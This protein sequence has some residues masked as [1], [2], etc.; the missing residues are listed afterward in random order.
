MKST[1]EKA[2]AIVKK[3]NSK[4]KETKEKERAINPDGLY[5]FKPA[6]HIDPG[7]GK[8]FVSIPIPVPKVVKGVPILDTQTMVVY[9][10]GIFPLNEEEFTAKRIFPRNIPALSFPPRWEMSDIQEFTSNVGNVDNVASV[11]VEKKNN[12]DTYREMF[13]ILLYL[14]DFQNRGQYTLYALWA[15]MTYVYP[16]F[17]AIPFINL[18]G[19]PGSGKSKV[20][21][22]FQQVCFN[23]ESTNNTS[24]AALFH[25]VELNMSTILIDE[26]EKLTGLEK[27][28]E[29][30]LLLNACYKKGGAVMRWNP[31]TKKIDRHYAYAPAL[32]AAINSLDPT[33]YQRCIG[34]V[35]LKTVTNKGEIV[36]SDNTYNWQDIRNRLYRFIFTASEEIEKIYLT[37]TF[38]GL[39]ARNLEK[40]APILSI[41][42][43]L[44]SSQDNTKIFDEVMSLAKEDI[45]N[46]DILTET[47][48][49]TLRAVDTVVTIGGEYFIKD[50][51]REMKH[52]LEEEGNNAKAIEDL[53]N[54]AIASILKKFGFRAGKRMTSGIPYRINRDQIKAAFMRYSLPGTLATSSTS[55]TDLMPET[56]MFY[57]DLAD[58]NVLNEQKEEKA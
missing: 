39:R 42:R 13:D 8:I 7:A 50:I 24:P 27:E 36:L 44:D 56:E 57:S 30:R 22:F 21:A 55:S 26:A 6:L 2:E 49:I 18:M 33:L 28:P 5:Y 23:A 34:H 52:I 25:T 17:N 35:I 9:R 43:Y 38:E 10:N 31:D 12:Y 20:V 37:E 53:T 47:E 48:E 11:P 29:L 45:E 46:T 54:K 4:L 51:K 19:T 15:M 3:T 58:K 14:F 16:I 40:W 32:I 1:F 41:A